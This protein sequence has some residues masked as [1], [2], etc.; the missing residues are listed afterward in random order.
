MKKKILGALVCLVILFVIQSHTAPEKFQKTKARFAHIVKPVTKPLTILAEGVASWYGIGDDT[1]GHATASTIAFDTTKP[2]CA[3]WGP[4]FGTWVTIENKSNHKRARCQILDRGPAMH[5]H[6][7][8]DLSHYVKEQIGM[9]DLGM[10]I[11]YL[12][13]S[14]GV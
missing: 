11:V 14:P 10:V 5:L 2:M 4:K 12:S 1:Q 8:I 9:S 3:M 13:K 7:A 6:R